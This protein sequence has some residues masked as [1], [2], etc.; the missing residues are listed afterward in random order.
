MGM[1]LRLKANFDISGF[2]ANDQVILTAFKKY[3]MIMADNGSSMYI[4]GTPDDRWDNDDLHNLSQV[5]ASDFEVVQMNPIY[6]AANVPQGSAPAISSFTANATTVSSGSS[7]TLSW[8]ATDAAYFIISPQI[9]AVRG[10]S[11]SVTPTQTTT[12]TLYATNQFGRNT[13]TITITVQ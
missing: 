4:G 9:G 2:S 11:V 12:Y 10:S 5:Q 8:D 7:V 13:S 6:T 3:G 1:R